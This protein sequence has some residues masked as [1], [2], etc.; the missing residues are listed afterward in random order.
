VS[1]VETSETVAADP[2]AVWRLVSDV[3]R[4]GEWSPETT[5]CRWI[6][7][8]SSPVVG[9]R[10]RGSN[11]HQFR[12]WSTTC[13]VT[14]AD[15]GR[16]F[17]FDVHY[18]PLPISSWSYEFS[19]AEGGTRVVEAW[20]DRRPSWMKAL[21]VPVMGVRDR[22]DHNRRGMQRTLTAVKRAAES[23]R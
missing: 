6:D 13:T 18:G 16:S 15:P 11:R 4:M 8:A 3:T 22:A 7:G 10:F 1:D 21:S 20:T 2:G 19:A 17:A 12:R 14:G 9:A 23:G 5:S